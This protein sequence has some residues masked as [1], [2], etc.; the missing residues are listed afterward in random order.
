M[1]RAA[2]ER[3]RFCVPRQDVRNG[4]ARASACPVRASRTRGFRKAIAA[5]SRSR[6][7]SQLQSVPVSA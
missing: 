7:G 6:R 4:G 3:T 2:P 5:A 1:I